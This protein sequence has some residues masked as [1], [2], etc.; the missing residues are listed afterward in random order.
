MSSVV[1]LAV[2]IT[3]GLVKKTAPGSFWD[4]MATSVV[5]RWGRF[6]ISFGL[7]MSGVR[8]LF[9]PCPR[10]TRRRAGLMPPLVLAVLWA[11]RRPLAVPRHGAPRA[12]CLD[13]QRRLH[14]R[15]RRQ[16]HLRR[17]RLPHV[18]QQRVERDHA[19]PRLDGRV[20]GRAQ[21]ARRLDGRHQPARQV[22]HRQQA[23]RHDVRAPRRP[24]QA[25][26][27]R[28]RASSSRT[29]LVRQRH[30]DGH[31]HLDPAPPHVQLGPLDVAVADSARPRRRC[32]RRAP[33]PPRA[34]LPPAPGRLDPLRRPR[35]RHPRVRPRPVRPSL[36][37][38]V[39]SLSVRRSS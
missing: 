21:P 12:L 13:D 11:R 6:P 3:D 30:R 10:R 26:R 34:V 24:A 7:L 25:R 18:R 32:R 14:H 20:P 16:R 29:D 1:L 22:R 9:L 36:H 2:L 19:R 8:P 4:P 37:S 35:H 23:P 27:A 15:L 33:H 5:P 38:T 17:L 31:V 39:L 28:P